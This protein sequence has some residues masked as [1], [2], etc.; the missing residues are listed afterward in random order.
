MSKRRLFLLPVL[1]LAVSLSCVAA[2]P[3]IGQYAP[4]FTLSTPGG[5]QV[6]LS[7]LNASGSVVLIVLRGYPGYQCPFSQLQFQSYQQSAAQFA[8]LGAQ[9]LF[10]YP[11]ADSKNLVEDARQMIGNTSLPSNVRVLLDPD[12]HFT[13]QYGLRWND[14]NQTAYPS[15][16]LLT[17]GGFV[18]YAHTGRTSSDQTP[19][20]DA[21]AVLTANTHSQKN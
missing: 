2:T 13:N 6:T 17:K 10:V 12:Y 3:G 18:I 15:T 4:D 5:E 7:S 8:A 19:P 20:A 9:V 14:A 21:L 1:L 11:G 16:F